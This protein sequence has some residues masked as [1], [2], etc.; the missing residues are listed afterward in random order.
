M[1]PNLEKQATLTAEKL[2][3]ILSYDPDIGVF[4]WRSLPLKQ[5]HMLGTIAGYRNKS[6][7]GY[8][9][10]SIGN[11]RYY[12][13]RLAWLYVTGEW[14]KNSI[15]HIDGDRH[16]NCFDNL[17][18]VTSAVNS[19]NRHYPQSGNKSGYVGAYFRRGQWY[20]GISVR[21]KS[22]WLGSH[23]SAEAAHSAYLQAKRK[24]H[25]GSTV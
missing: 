4:R 6:N 9:S 13:H 2:R 12:I 25:E 15:D 11:K 19:E 23:K 7:Y 24:Y 10:I 8:C 14:P 21:G 22:I 16:N 20:S 17:R 1:N 5:S 3:Q 18:D